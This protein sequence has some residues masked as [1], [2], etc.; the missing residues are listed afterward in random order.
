MISSR[1]KKVL[2]RMVGDP[3]TA[4]IFVVPRLA[5]PT[6][7]G[8][9]V[10]LVTSSVNPL[11]GALGG[12]LHG[13]LAG[14]LTGVAQTRYPVARLPAGVQ[15]ASYY[16]AASPTNLHILGWNHW[17]FGDPDVNQLVKLPLSEVSG[18]IECATRSGLAIGLT[19]E[20][21]NG[22]AFDF[23]SSRLLR[24]EISKFQQ[25][26]ALQ[27][28]DKASASMDRSR[29]MGDW[30]IYILDKEYR[31]PDLQTV[32]RWCAEGRVPTSAH[33]VAPGTTEWKRADELPD[34]KTLLSRH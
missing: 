6:V 26:F 18:V 22:T 8:S 29:T 19:V 32:Q 14:A 30:R 21:K 2:A 11:G 10:S 3:I 1:L 34:T 4:G 27:G 31:A 12:A 24:A 9:L 20:L 28:S 17:W 23:E 33:I 5:T 25:R 7:V 15:Y 16:L 13:A